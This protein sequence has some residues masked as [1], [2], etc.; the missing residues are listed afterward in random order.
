MVTQM[1]HTD[2]TSTS[3][4]DFGFLFC[5]FF[6][7]IAFWPWIGQAFHERWWAII[8]SIVFFCAALFMPGLL[9]G[10][11]YLWMKLAAFL[12]RINNKIIL[13]LLFFLILTPLA[14]IRRYFSGDS[15]GL[16][17]DP[18]STS[19]RSPVKPRPGEHI[20]HQF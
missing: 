20:D 6:A 19:Y 2:S 14:L 8:L 18:S 4:R 13:G 5:G 1:P 11:Y 3:L 12:G 16:Q 9:R 15:L 7:L 17:F 10:P